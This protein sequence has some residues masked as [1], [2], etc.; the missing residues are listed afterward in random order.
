MRLISLFAAA[1]GF[2]LVLDRQGSL[3]SPQAAFK[4]QRVMRLHDCRAL[5]GDTLRC[6]NN[7]IRLI[8]IDA[9]EL[10]GHCRAGRECAPGD[11]YAQ[12]DA[13]QN[14]IKAELLARA[15][16]T[17]RFGRIVSLVETSDGIN[18]S[19]AMLEAG[20]SYKP[21]W[22]DGNRVMTACPIIVKRKLSSD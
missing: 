15:I 3:S 18:V 9:A 16:K 4:P 2:V 8:G 6:G 7:R 12:R 21:R 19:C 10:A 17:D 13:L 14:L 5:D 1:L 22:D 11:P 20:A